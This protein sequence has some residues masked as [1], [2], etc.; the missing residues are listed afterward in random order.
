MSYPIV[1]RKGMVVT[2][3]HTGYGL[4][5]ERYQ[6]RF[7]KKDEVK[8]QQKLAKYQELLAKLQGKTSRFFQ[9]V[10]ARR[11]AR[12]EKKIQAI[13]M[14]LGTQPFDASME[15]EA[16]AIAAQNYDAGYS[17]GDL[18]L[19]IALAVTAGVGIFILVRRQG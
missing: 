9:N 19:P 16:M 8:L 7:S 13:Q 1:V 14:L 10:R 11:I 5:T 18:V 17:G 2:P 3:Q 6:K 4:T 15:A 12:T